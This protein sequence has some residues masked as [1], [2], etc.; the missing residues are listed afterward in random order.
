MPIP[1]QITFRGLE[2]S[3]TIESLIR[4]KARRM[5]RFFNRI[6]SCHVFVE[7][8]PQHRQK[9]GTYHVTVKL[10]VPGADLAVSRES[11]KNHAHE[12]LRV[13]LRDAFDAAVRRLEDHSRAGHDVK[14]RRGQGESF[15]RREHPPPEG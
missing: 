1:L 8:P 12:S 7:A 3:E 5:E 10:V 14:T 4:E 9:G 6:S 2:P 13:A 15:H 11:G